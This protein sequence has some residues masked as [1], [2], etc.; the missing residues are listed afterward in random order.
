[1]FSIGFDLTAEG[2]V[3]REQPIVCIQSL[4]EIKTIFCFTNLLQR[5]E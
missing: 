3:L 4:I 5:K 2:I 1:M